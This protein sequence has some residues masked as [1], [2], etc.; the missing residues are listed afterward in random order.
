MIEYLK[1][2]TK[3]NL[4]KYIPYTIMAVIMGILLCVNINTCTNLHN[5][6]HN[7]N[8]SRDSVRTLVLKNGEHVST[9]NSYILKKRELE[10]YLDISKSEIKELEKKLD[11]KVAYVSNTVTEV[12][13]HD[14][15]M[16]DTIHI[17]DTSTS[18]YNIYYN[19]QWLKLHGISII[20]DSIVTTTLDTIY[21]PVPLQVGLTDDYQIWVKSKNPYLNVTSIE[22]AVI[23]GSKLN[24]K[25]KYWGLGIQGG[26][27]VNYGIINKR[28]D[29]GPYIGIGISYNLF[30]W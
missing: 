13:Y 20:N 9:I 2:L 25:T 24:Q 29:V 14:I 1:Y 10:E 3:E 6:E 11:S 23:E 28:I 19:D 17:M 18:S 7:L 8:V 22:G 30:R 21:I 15:M 27:G 5:A 12:Q 26:I 4:L 16:H